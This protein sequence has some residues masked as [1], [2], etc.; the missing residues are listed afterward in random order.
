MI[1][2]KGRFPQLFVPSRKICFLQENRI[3]LYAI[4]RSRH[5]KGNPLSRAL[6]FVSPEQLLPFRAVSLPECSSLVS[7]RILVPLLIYKIHKAWN[8]FEVTG[9]SDLLPSILSWIAFNQM[10]HS[11]FICFNWRYPFGLHGRGTFFSRLYRI[12]ST[13]DLSISIPSKDIIAIGSPPFISFLCSLE[14]PCKVLSP[15][16]F[17][18]NVHTRETIHHAPPRRFSNW[19]FGCKLL[20]APWPT[21][22][23][24]TPLSERVT[25]QT[26]I[27]RKRGLT[28]IH[29]RPLPAV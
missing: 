16:Q 24:I 9:M 17:L 14:V 12:P 20:A 7:Q 11:S 28:I 13:E 8:R 10:P 21:A 6:T 18:L 19:L 15:W 27:R 2:R 5:S 29:A 3:D 25:K 4:V 26:F 23:S 1:L 22:P